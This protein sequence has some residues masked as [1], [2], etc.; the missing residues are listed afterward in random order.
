MNILVT[1]FGNFGN[2][3]ENP[4]QILVK[5]LKQKYDGLDTFIFKDYKSINDN[6]ESLLH[7]KPDI[8]LMFGLASKT[9]YVRLE[10]NARR[11]DKLD[12]EEQYLGKLPLE[13][14][15]ASLS[16]KNIEVRYSDSAGSYLCN[17]LFYKVCRLR[18]HNKSS[19]HGLIH[20]PSPSVYEQKYKKKLDLIT[21][22]TAVLDFV[23]DLK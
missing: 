14:I 11:P 22:G 10:Q 12:G 15:Y 20:I 8:I 7:H 19:Q 13:K 16:D 1:G 2:T 21:L 6:V 4:S 17:Y 9:P 5:L 18:R 3:T 23:V